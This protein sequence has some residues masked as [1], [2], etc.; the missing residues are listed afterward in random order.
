MIVLKGMARRAAASRGLAVASLLLLADSTL[1]AV[2]AAAADSAGCPGWSRAAGHDAFRIAW[3]PYAE[4]LVVRVQPSLVRGSE[5]APIAVA[6]RNDD[7][8][9]AVAEG[10]V[11]PGDVAGEVALHLPELAAGSYTV[12]LSLPTVA[13]CPPAR[14]PIERFEHRIFGWEHNRLGLTDEVIPPFTDLTVEEDRVRSVLREHTIGPVG[15]WSQVASMGLPLLAEP[16]RLEIATRE[17]PSKVEPSAPLA[18][19]RHSATRVQT[20]AAFE[21]G[22]LSGTV[23]GRFEMDGLARMTIEVDGAPSTWVEKMDLVLPLDPAT[24]RFFHAIGDRTRRHDLGELPPGDGVMWTSERAG[25][26]ELPSGFVPYIWIGD[27]TRG[28]SW[29][30]DGTRDWWIA[31]DRAVQSITRSQGVVELRIHLVTRPGR[32]E[33]QRRIAFALQATPVKPRPDGWRSWYLSCNAPPSMYGICPLGAGWYWGA[34]SPYGHVYPRDRDE[35]V[36]ALLAGARR[37]H[38]PPERA[39]DDWLDRHAVVGE[40]REKSRASVLFSIRKLALRPDAVVAYINSHMAA[41]SPEFAVYTDEWRNEPFG[42]RDGR[43]PRPSRINV[44]PVRSFQ[45]F[46]LWHLDRL[47]ASGAVDGFFFDNTFLRAW[48]DERFGTAWRPDGGPIRPG[49]DL[50]EMRELL[51]RAQVL[52]WQRRGQWLNVAHMTSTPIAAV[53]AWAGI[54]LDGEWEYGLDDYQDRF[55]RTLMRSASLGSTTGTVPVYLPGLEGETSP[56]RRHQLERSLASVTALHEIRVQRRAD[57][58]LLFLWEE[59]MKAG[60]ASPDCTVGRYWDEPPLAR[61]VGGDAEVLLVSCGEESLALVVSYGASG[62]IDLVLDESLAA[63]PS[64]VRCSDLERRRTFRS[65]D[66][67]PGCRIPIERHDFR[68]IRIEDRTQ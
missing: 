5:S 13:G 27:E 12:A 62:A 57:G 17:G 41:W 18:I 6:I 48:F 24:A 65:L 15:L 23:E 31:P 8:G 30:A 53:H 29:M 9:V 22:G 52:V 51:M 63:T 10:E 16:M 11:R 55:S 60:Y 34:A 56:K 4:Q 54:N 36:L 66:S 39:V 67:V 1:G 26:F 61:V 19:E 58:P 49:V 38:R 25:G 44:V 68:L 40:P 33:R 21:A 2:S 59:L 64:F 20:K 32:L 43:V 7:T 35:S 14:G 46:M 47:L 28:L 3:Y 42:D 45:D 37:G 50:F